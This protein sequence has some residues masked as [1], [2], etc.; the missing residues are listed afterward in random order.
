MSDVIGFLFEFHGFVFFFFKNYL[1]CKIVTKLCSCLILG[2]IHILIFCISGNVF[3]CFVLLN[4]IGSK[5]KGFDNLK[6]LLEGLR[7]LDKPLAFF[8]RLPVALRG[9]WRI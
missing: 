7:H 2:L 4:K 6:Q 8:R 3:F 9:L 1:T 5:I